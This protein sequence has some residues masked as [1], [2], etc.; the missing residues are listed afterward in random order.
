MKQSATLHYTLCILRQS[1]HMSRFLTLSVGLFIVLELACIVS[2]CSSY[3]I[4]PFT[5]MGGKADLHTHECS[6]ETNLQ[7]TFLTGH[8]LLNG[9]CLLVN[10]K[11][12]KKKR[13]CGGVVV[14]ITEPMCLIMW[15][16]HNAL[17]LCTVKR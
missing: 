16:E 12:K 5:H 8:T 17:L 1:A 7:E 13:G 15:N 4:D 2:T 6:M 9:F 14:Q 11:L 3:S 10:V